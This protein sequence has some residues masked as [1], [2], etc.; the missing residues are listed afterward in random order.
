[1]AELE[2]DKAGWYLPQRPRRMQRI[3]KG[4]HYLAI[5]VAQSWSMAGVRR[6][7][8]PL[9]AAEKAP[10]PPPRSFGGVY[11]ERSRTAQD[12]PLRSRR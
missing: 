3:G 9:G 8:D 6:V 12:R 10:Y 4:I 2:K 5:S 1:M 11:S 7:T